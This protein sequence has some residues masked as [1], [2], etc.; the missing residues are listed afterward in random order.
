MSEILSRELKE[1][2]IGNDALATFIEFFEYIGERDEDFDA[3]SNEQKILKVL[4]KIFSDP[5][6]FQK[7][8]K[9][10]ESNIDQNAFFRK[11]VFFY[12][13]DYFS[14]LV[15]DSVDDII[16]LPSFD[17]I[18]LDMQISNIPS[19]STSYAE[20][21]G[22]SVKRNLYCNSRGEII[23]FI[24]SQKDGN[25][26]YSSQGWFHLVDTTWGIIL[27]DKWNNI[28]WKSKL[29][30]IRL[31]NKLLS[32]L[33]WSTIELSS[34]E[35]SVLDEY[36]NRI[37]N[38]DQYYEDLSPRDTRLFNLK[39]RFSLSTEIQILEKEFHVYRWELLSVVI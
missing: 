4:N 10:I 5:G 16:S 36:I 38:I 26:V 14:W 21:L 17:E 8:I 18:E 23:Y 29:N 12:A 22:E 28:L 25:L 15:I 39:L 13:C 27:H 11:E 7:Y 32:Y 19:T 37:I 6:A 35:R 30:K 1:Q 33:A 34:W 24:E 9:F 3:L 31:Y 20:A 2:F